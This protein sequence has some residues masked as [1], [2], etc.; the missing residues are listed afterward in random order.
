[1][2]ICVYTYIYMLFIA[3]YARL[4]L[5]PICVQTLSQD[6][7]QHIVIINLIIILIISCINYKS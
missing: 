5:F 3:H 1:M 7:Y 6:N 4:L 2:N